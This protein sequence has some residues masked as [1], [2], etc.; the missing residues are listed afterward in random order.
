MQINSDIDRTLYHRN[1]KT[2]AYHHPEFGVDEIK[3]TE[4]NI[5]ISVD[6][7]NC[8][9]MKNREQVLDHFREL[10]KPAFWKRIF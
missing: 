7:K 2:Y 1:M 6:E 3:D 8:F 4:M 9:T 10:E 5:D